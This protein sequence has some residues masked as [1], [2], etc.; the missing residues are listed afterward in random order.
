MGE[1]AAQTQRNAMRSLADGRA[2][3]VEA[4]V[5]RP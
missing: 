3:A 2:I 4:L 1:R 5:R